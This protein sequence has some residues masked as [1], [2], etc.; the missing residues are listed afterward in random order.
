MSMA[1]SN[2]RVV[3]MKS[4]TKEPMISWDSRIVIDNKVSPVFNI[5]YRSQP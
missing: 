4:F 2:S 3:M 5:H 1:D